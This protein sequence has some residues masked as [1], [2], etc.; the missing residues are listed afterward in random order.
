MVLRLD[1]RRRRAIYE[2]EKHLQLIMR[3]CVLDTMCDIQRCKHVV[4]GINLNDLPIDLHL[5]LTTHDVVVLVKS[6]LPISVVQMMTCIPSLAP[7]GMS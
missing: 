3:V 4:S 6:T 7:G 1:L 2:S 5:T